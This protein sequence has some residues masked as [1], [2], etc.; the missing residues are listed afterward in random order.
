MLREVVPNL[1]HVAVLANAGYPAAMR[2]A[3]EAENS[4][5]ALGLETI[6]LEIRQAA[7]IAPAFAALGSRAEAYI[8]VSMPW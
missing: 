5:R 1:R 3:H 6:P 7:D 8:L 2:E 4:A